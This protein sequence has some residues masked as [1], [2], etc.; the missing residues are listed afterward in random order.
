MK[1]IRAEISDLQRLKAFYDNVTDNTVGMD[2][3]CRWEK[4]LYPTSDIIRDHIEN[5]SMYILDEDN[6]VLGA[7]ALTEGQDDSYKTVNWNVNAA[8]NEIAVIHILGVNPAL[9]GLGMGKRMV[10]YAIDLSA[11][12]NKKAVRLDALSSNVPAQ[13]MYKSLGFKYVGTQKFK[14]DNTGLADFLL[15]EK[16][17]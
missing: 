1:L 10:K 17:L 4:G 2:Q 16:A 8:D 7:M 14:Y 6:K 13:N 5:H 12:Q 11:A 3:Y 15:F 9:Q